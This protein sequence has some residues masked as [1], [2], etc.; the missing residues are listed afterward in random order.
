MC[1]C[2]WHATLLPSLSTL[3][4][5]HVAQLSY[6]RGINYHRANT[7]YAYTDSMVLQR[8]VTEAATV[9]DLGGGGG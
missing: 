9:V 4:A 6:V 1:F 8:D 5:V 3:A 7:S 2:V